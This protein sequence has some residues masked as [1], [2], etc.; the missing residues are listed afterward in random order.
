MVSLTTISEALKEIFTEYNRVMS[1]REIIQIINQR[2]ATNKWKESSLNAHLYGCSVNNPPAYTQ[3]PSQPKFLFDHGQRRYE[4]YI[5]EKHG[6]YKDGYL[7]GVK[8]PPDEDEEDEETDTAQVTFGLERDL[9]EYISRNLDQIE[10]GLK[11]YSDGK[12]SGQQYPTDVGRIDLLALDKSE[13]YVV[14]EL[15]AGKAIDHVLGQIL[16]YMSH[17]RK[18]LANG[19]E[20]RGII[21]ADDFDERLKYAAE[22]IP[23]L[24]LKKY[25]VKFE[26]E[27]I[28]APPPTNP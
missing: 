12:N 22:E 26:F 23:K 17:V 27:D 7:E 8:P 18:K 15:K 24:K 16:G 4:L 13:S 5:A 11:L 20:V 2:Y 21:V 14:I 25:L 10:D 6:K 9:E 28:K 1:A 19:K 3:H